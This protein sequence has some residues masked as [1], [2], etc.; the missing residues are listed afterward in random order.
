MRSR[1]IAYIFGLSVFWALPKPSLLL[2]PSISVGLL[3]VFCLFFKKLRVLILFALSGVLPALLQYQFYSTQVQNLPHHQQTIMVVGEITRVTPHWPRLVSFEIDVVKMDNNKIEGMWPIKLKLSWYLRGSSPAKLPRLGEFWQLPVRIKPIHGFANPFAFDY[4]RWAL[5]HFLMAKGYVRIKENPQLLSVKTSWMIKTAQRLETFIQ[6]SDLTNKAL[7][8]A[9]TT[10]NKTQLSENLREQLQQSGLAHLL[11]ISG[12]H[13]GIMALVGHM[14]VSVLWR[15]SS[16][17]TR[18]MNRQDAAL[19]GAL[20]LAALYAGLSGWSVPTLRA[21]VMLGIFC[22]TK[23]LRLRW[24]L[25]DVLLLAAVVLFTLNPLLIIDSSTWLS[26]GAVL[27]IAQLLSSRIKT[28]ASYTDKLKSWL[29]MTVGIWLAM[30]PLTLLIFSQ[31]STLGFVSNFFAIPLMSFFIMPLMTMG[32]ML[33]PI[34]VD[35]AQWV[36]TPADWGLSLIVLLSSRTSQLSFQ[37]ARDFVPLMLITIA[38]TGYILPRTVF[39]KK[40]VILLL[41]VSGIAY[42]L[43]GKN[44]HGAKL[45]VFDI[46]HGLAV[47][48]QQGEQ[49]IL[50]DTGAGSGGYSVLDNTVLPYLNA[51][52]ISYLDLLIVSHDD[53]DHSGGLKTLEK[54]N[55]SIPLATG[56]ILNSELNQALCHE[57]G[58]MKAGNTTLR[59]LPV[60]GQ[61]NK[62]NN[63][64]C[65]LEINY[66]EHLILL[67]GDVEARR[68]HYLLKQQRLKPVD[69]LLAPHHGSKTSSS[70]AFVKA[71][72][73]KKVIYSTGFLNHFNFPHPLVQQRYQSTGAE[74]FNTAVDGAITCIW[75]QSGDFNGCTK[76]RKKYWGKWHW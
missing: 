37:L 2:W 8:Q 62:D 13:I 50:Y 61:E 66:K 64:S 25:L 38:C 53:N 14:L 26:F 17:L 20:L 51:S 29:H 56:Q 74:S 71:V 67:P 1:M 41:F 33:L 42:Y 4:E 63:H 73:P 55:S 24:A 10:G 76:T 69:V 59:F 31:F 68:E 70:Q 45:T 43:Q 22:I 18:L 47:L 75:Q 60:S 52:G 27:I 54:F 3:V 19:I 34:S 48:W 32:A 36:L 28:E 7:L 16:R 72:H 65:V 49:V 30:I 57:V 6:D 40:L 12:L 21:I 46:G 23:W 39:P 9:L 58:L 11:A 44:V 35:V 15:L 5:S